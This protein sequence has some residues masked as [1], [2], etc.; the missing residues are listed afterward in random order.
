MK[1]VLHVAKDLRLIKTKM[2]LY[3]FLNEM[4][5]AGAMDCK[6]PTR[7]Q[8]H[9][10]ISVA[11]VMLALPCASGFGGSHSSHAPFP[12]VT[13]SKRLSMD[14]H[15]SSSSYPSHPLWKHKSPFLSRCSSKSKSIIT[16]TATAAELGNSSDSLPS[17]Q[18]R[19]RSGVVVKTLLA[20]SVTAIALA[21]VC[22]K[23]VLLAAVSS[24]GPASAR[25]NEWLISQL[26]NLNNAGTPGLIAYSLAFMLWEMTVGMTTPI[27]TA[28]GMAFGVKKG[29]LANAIGKIGCA[30]TAFF[31]GRFILFDYVHKKLSSNEMLTLVEESIQEHPLGVALLFRL[32]PLPEF[33]KNFGLSVLPIKSR[34]FFAALLLH[35]LPFTCLWT[36]LGAETSRVMRGG[37]PSATLKILI[38]GVSWFGEFT[39]ERV[40][41]LLYHHL[42]QHLRARAP[43]SSHA[44]CL[45]NRIYF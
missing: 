23:G 33:V 17:Q 25:L 45:P 13:G 44:S 34:F 27:E 4:K 30:V 28:A 22:N 19:T 7:R 38:S 3:H 29:I 37:N 5:N 36:C 14:M 18:E 42:A 15:T 39:K 2:I 6:P 26:D 35:G 41:Y 12:G 9:A 40:I 24:I 16:T 21:A 10:F 32:S 8:G 43:F 31:L 1:H 11:L 20:A